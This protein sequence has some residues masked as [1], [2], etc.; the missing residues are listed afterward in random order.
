MMVVFV[1]F[2]QD[3]DDALLHHHAA[4]AAAD[5]GKPGLHMRGINHEIYP[6][7][8]RV[9]GIADLAPDDGRENPNVNGFSAVLSCYP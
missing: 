5:N 9:M 2:E 4:A 8:E 1:D 6:Q 7:Q 3:G